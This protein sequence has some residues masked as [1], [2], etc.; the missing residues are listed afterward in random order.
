M[1]KVDNIKRWGSEKFVPAMSKLGQL[2]I[3]QAL[4]SGMMMTLPLT[5]GAAIFSL[6]GS[7]PIPVVASYFSEIGLSGQFNA[8]AGGTMGV[9]A[10]FTTLAI[11]YN[12]A[13]LLNVKAITAVLFSIAAF[14]VLQPQIITVGEK[15]VGGF[16]SSNLGSSGI[17]VS[18]IVS[19]LIPLSYAKLQKNK[20]LLLKLP[21]SVPP[22]VTQSFEPIFV[23]LILLL[24][25]FVIRVGFSL[26]SFGDIFSFINEIIAQPLMTIGASVPSLFIVY[27][28]ANI[29]FF[30]GIHPNAI[31][32][33]LTPVLLP[34]M[35]MSIDQYNSG[36]TVEY[37]QN[38]VVFDFMNNDGTGSTLSL[39]ICIL[40]FGKSKRYKSFAKLGTIPNIFNINE[41]VIFGF[42][43]MLNPI[44]F[45]PFVLSTVVSGLIGFIALKIGFIA[46]YNPNFSAAIIP[47]TVPKFIAGFFTMGWQGVVLRLLIMVVIVFLYYPFFK[48][49]DN[50]ELKA[51]KEN[52]LKESL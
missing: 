19:I 9:L 49:L 33:V 24:A 46:A 29:L 16:L 18:M 37:L 6:L 25:I 43:I 51:E 21:D 38:L 48:I 36:Q 17:F 32:S 41:P 20:K 13:M 15:S 28:L 35:M 26:T 4:S 22:M 44:M 27:V 5:L 1:S 7:F 47:W 14:F 3:L 40:I 52:E 31:M 45:V 42:P 39:M 8:V 23:G 11:S 12:Y 10:I 2:K 34:M 30:F 50:Q